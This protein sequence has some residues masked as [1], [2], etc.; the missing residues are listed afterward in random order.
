MSK[1]INLK[2]WDSIEKLKNNF[3]S[4]ICFASRKSGKSELIKCIYEQCNFG[5]EYDH[6]IVMSECMDTLDFFSNFVHGNLFFNEFSSNYIQNIISQS[7]KL[8]FENNK[9]KFLL[10]IDDVV[11]NTIKYSE[12]MQRIYAVGR[13]YR[14][15]CIL[16]CQK[17][18]LIN[19]AVRN[20]SDLILIGRSKTA[21][22]KKSIIENLLDGV[23]DKNDIK[24]YGMSTKDEF[25]NTLLK[26]HTSDYNFIVL[27]FLDQKNI[28]FDEVVKTYKA[29]LS[30]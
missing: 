3:F 28:E 18:T 17:L 22:E 14:I 4:I 1:K 27:D 23:I 30:Q 15:S 10:I 16:I 26:E 7:E 6:V 9:K 11:G 8:E 12:V 19:T 21:Q 13:H 24:N 29:K 20:N 5:D 25:Y 2:E